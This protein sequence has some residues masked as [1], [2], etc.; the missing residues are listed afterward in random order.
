MA[1]CR[2]VAHTHGPKQSQRGS[3]GARPGE[4][5][6]PVRAWLM[7]QAGEPEAVLEWVEVLEPTPGPGE[8]QVSVEYAGLGFPDLLLIRGEYQVPLP[9][10]CVPGSEFVGRVRA[11][12]PETTVEPGT[13]LLGLC[14]MGR[15]SFADV[16]VAPESYCEPIPEDLPGPG[17]VCLIGNYVTAHLAL[18]RRA[19]LQPGEVVVV[20]GAAGGVGTAAIQIAKASGAS[21]IAADVGEDRAES[22]RSAG[23]D[24][25]VDV[26][27]VSRLTDA[28]NEHTDGRGADVV[29][30]MV[31]GDLFEAARRFIAPEGRIVIVGFTSGTIPHIRLNQVLLRNFGVMGVNALTV[32]REYPLVHREARRAVVELL[33]RK[34]VDPPIAGI[35]PLEDLLDVASALYNR[36]LL[37]KPV[38]KVSVA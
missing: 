22:C 9:L 30:D 34:A 32:L 13:R 35:Y 12:G 36:K 6:T 27:D 28:V 25:I 20:H 17:A 11:A 7:T 31:G 26:T 3:T 14:E 5:I 10:P 2:G 38:L 18:H 4:S 29:L 8:L 19:A 15:G 33:A 24:V 16:G 1:L 37:G 23:A 21:V